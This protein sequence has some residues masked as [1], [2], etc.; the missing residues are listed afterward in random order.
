[1]L[2]GRAQRNPEKGAKRQAANK[3][4]S[5]PHCAPPAPR[6][7]QDPDANKN[8]AAGT[9]SRAPAQA[10]LQA[11]RYCNAFALWWRCR[12]RNCRR[13]RACLGDA[14]ACLK[15]ALVHVPASLQAQVRQ[16]ILDATPHNIGAPE[17]EARQYTARD[18]FR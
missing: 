13:H 11:R 7:R 9:R 1:L 14:H 18:Y 2:A 5:S 17:R 15:R 12:Q 3:V 10:E 6:R 4:I 16:K 8:R